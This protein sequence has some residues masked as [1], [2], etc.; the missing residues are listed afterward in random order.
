MTDKQAHTEH[1]TV[2]TAISNA[3][4]L[5]YHAELE[6]NLAAVE[7]LDSLADSWLNMAAFL[8]ECGR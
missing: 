7:R 5:L 3:A 8:S 6:T 4:R 2:D 1:V